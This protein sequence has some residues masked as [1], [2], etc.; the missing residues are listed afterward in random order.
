[1]KNYSFVDYLR[2]TAF[3]KQLQLLI[4]T[5]DETHYYHAELFDLNHVVEDEFGSFE[6][7]LHKKAFKRIDEF[8]IIFCGFYLGES[9]AP[10]FSFY[11]YEDSCEFDI[12][13]ID[14]SNYSVFCLDNKQFDEIC[15]EEIFIDNSWKIVL[16]SFIE[17]IKMI[18]N[19][20][21]KV[22]NEAMPGMN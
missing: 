10:L 1:M 5:E 6:K 8:G 9:E 3:L 7:I 4:L 22:Q 15:L 11:M 20:D 13:K 14:L 18:M 2:V 16:S 19:L 17:K 21:I 12:A